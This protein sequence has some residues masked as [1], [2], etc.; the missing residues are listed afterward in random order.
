MTY[1]KQPVR[2]FQS[3]ME[4]P[5]QMGLNK[6]NPDS[7]FLVWPDNSFQ[8]IILKKDS[9][10]QEIRYKPGLPAFDYSMLNRFYTNDSPVWEDIT[11]QTDL[12]Y[13]HEENPFIEFDR[14]PLMPFMVSGKGLHWQWLI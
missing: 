7:V 12:L 5:L 2:G 1:E 11:R 14:E 6:I 13:R 8:Q 9:L 10:L 4:M 3:S